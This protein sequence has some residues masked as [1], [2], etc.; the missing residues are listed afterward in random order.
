MYYYL[1]LNISNLSQIFTLEKRTKFS[2]KLKSS[3]Q[4][5]AQTPGLRDSKQNRVFRQKKPSLQK[6]P[7]KGKILRCLVKT[8]W[9]FAKIR[10]VSSKLCGDSSKK[11]SPKLRGDS[12]KKKQAKSTKN[13][14][15]IYWDYG[16]QIKWV[17]S[18]KLRGDS[19]SV[20]LCV[21]P[22]AISSK[23]FCSFLMSTGFV[24]K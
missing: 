21:F 10:V 17:V 20:L 14:G 11:N 13:T 3:R 22:A 19:P 6:S 8:T 23:I 7:K 2:S 15:K 24:R 16:T 9:R 5:T 4:H 12:S 18:S 1:L